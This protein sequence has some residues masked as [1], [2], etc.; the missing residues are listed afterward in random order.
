MALWAFVALVVC[1]AVG[2]QYVVPTYRYFKSRI[3]LK[4]ANEFVEKEDYNSASL[5][6]RKAILSGNSD[7]VVWKGVAA[8]SERIRSP[9]IG[10]IWETLSGLEPDVLEHKI[11]HAEVMLEQGRSLQTAEIL[12]KLP[13]TAKETAAFQRVSAKLALSKRDYHAAAEHFEQWLAIEPNNSEV[14]FKLLVAQMHSSDPLIAYP[15]KEKVEEIAQASVPDSPQ[16][17]R[18]LVA[19]SLKEGNIYDAARLAGRLVDLPDPTFEDMATFLDLELGSKSFA[20]QLAI[21]RFLKFAEVDPTQLPNVAN[22][23]L[24]RGQVAPLAKW[25]EK[26]P[27]SVIEHPDAQST[28]FQIALVT[29]N[30]ISAFALLRDKKLLVQIP[31]PVLDLAERAFAQHDGG[32]KEADQT[33]QQVIYAVQGN[34][35]ALQ[36][37]SLMA[38]AKNWPFAVGRSLSALSNLASANLDVWLRLA[39]HEALTGNLAGYYSALTG[40]MHVNP[41]DIWV[42]ADWV[43]T[44]ALL[45]K[46]DPDEVI[47]TAIRAYEATSPANPNVAT[48]YAVA[49]LGLNRSDEALSV[50]EKMSLTDRTALKRSI[51]VGAVLAAAGRNEEALECFRRSEEADNVRFIEELGFRRIWTG[52]A[53]GEESAEEQLKKIFEQWM[54]GEGDAPR[55]AIELQREIDLRYDPV[56]S[57]RILDD[58]QRQA[59]DRRSSPTELRRLVH[60][61]TQVPNPSE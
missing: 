2:F 37:F 11:R 9:E 52:I 14:K 59:Q 34:P 41:Y 33:W 10:K 26:L 1:T 48:A 38:E 6:F 28:R 18:E 56:Q 24:E 3:Y 54:G 49:L 8:F 36:L 61:L 13:T 44:S 46:G 57:Q 60:D 45:R 55:I 5:A 15:A 23:M 12:E 7:P 29:Q 40:M 16:A 4:M 30:W 50:V 43:L 42:S 22:F 53:K 17:Y 27:K 32:D 58:L 47:K 19:R 25:M 35:G 51:Y 21:D 20:V 31:E 39:R